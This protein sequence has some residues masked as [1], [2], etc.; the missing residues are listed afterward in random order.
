MHSYVFPGARCMKK[1]SSLVMPSSLAPGTWNQERY[2]KN[3]YV[4]YYGMIVFIEYAQDLTKQHLAS[5]DHS[6]IPNSHFWGTLVFPQL[7]TQCT[8]H[9]AAPVVKMFHNCKI[10]NII[11][12]YINWYNTKKMTNLCPI[13]G[14]CLDSMAIKKWPLGIEIVHI[15]VQ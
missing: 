5:N 8:Q 3:W 10:N 15:S 9:L 13:V 4:Q 12:T 6:A 7:P 2:T 11:H 1:I 14:G